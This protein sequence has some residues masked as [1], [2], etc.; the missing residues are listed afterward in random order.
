MAARDGLEADPPPALPKSALPAQSK[1]STGTASGS[2]NSIDKSSI[3]YLECSSKE[4]RGSTHWERKG[5]GRH[6]WCCEVGASTQARKVLADILGTK[7]Q[8]R[9]GKVGSGS[10]MGVGLRGCGAAGRVG[11]GKKGQ[12]R[13]G[14]RGARARGGGRGPRVLTTAAAEAALLRQAPDGGVTKVGGAHTCRGQ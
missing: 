5:R 4:S 8:A 6:C 12:W 10:V 2:S 11:K 13:Q 7:G 3:S 1:S 9:L 14:E